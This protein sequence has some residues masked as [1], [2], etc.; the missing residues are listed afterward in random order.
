M[1]DCYNCKYKGSVPGSAH[2]RCNYVTNE[3]QALMLSLDCF[4]LKPIEGMK[5]NQHGIANGWCI[6]PLNFDPTWVTKCSY[7]ETKN[8]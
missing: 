5:F 4:S 1:A 3:T 8:K 2:S 7:F 6:W